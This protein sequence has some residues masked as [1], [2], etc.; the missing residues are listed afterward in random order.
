M[1]AIVDESLGYIPSSYTSF[2]LT[3]IAKH[4]FVHTWGTIREVVVRFE[5]RS[6]IV[7]VQQCIESRLAQSVAAVGDDVG[8]RPHEDAEISVIC[9]HTAD[10]LRQIVVPCPL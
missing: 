5:Q 1:E 7:R 8:K 2:C 4:T 10:R 9:A 6:E 3:I